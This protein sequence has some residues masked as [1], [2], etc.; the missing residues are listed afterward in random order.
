MHCVMVSE[1]Y[2][3]FKM[4]TYFQASSLWAQ[5]DPCRLSYGGFLGRHYKPLDIEQIQKKDTF[6]VVVLG[7]LQE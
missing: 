7:Q 3:W 2:W 6:K 1:H 5:D 4:S